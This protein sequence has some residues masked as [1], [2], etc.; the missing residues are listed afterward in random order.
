MRV[1]AI[2]LLL[3]IRI[4]VARRLLR[5]RKSV[6]S[7]QRESHH[8]D[9]PTC[10]LGLNYLDYLVVPASHSNRAGFEALM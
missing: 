5:K 8:S 9:N 7:E 3:V 1:I 6:C 2:D 10:S 4:S